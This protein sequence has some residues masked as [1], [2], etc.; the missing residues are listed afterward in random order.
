MPTPV[1]PDRDVVLRETRWVAVLIIPVLL[2]AF[3]I[4][5]FFPDSSGEHFAWPIKPRMSAMMLGATYFTGAIY[6]SVV[7]RSKAWHQVRLGLL[8]VVLFASILG[9][10][11]IMHWD[12]FS[13][14][15]PQFW[16]WV[17]L[18]W[19]LPFVLLW[20]WIR[21]E[22]R[23]RPLG[24]V[25]DEV[26]LNR[27]TR[28]LIGLIGAGLAVTSIA[29]FAIPAAVIALWPWKLSSLTARITS[30]ELGLFAFFMLEVALVGRWSEVRKLLFPQLVSPVI[31]VVSVL[32][33]WEN[34]DQSNPFT[35]GFVAFV[36]IVFLV[37][38]PAL[39]FPMESKRKRLARSSA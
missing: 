32:V 30:A 18:Y 39:Y 21:N 23:A 26:F 16:L 7:A 6:F 29:L 22:R 4:L 38:F 27:R 25:A 1:H 35:W 17:V 24:T 3:V 28:P 9:I 12:K 14:D 36:L 33:S 37:G 34:F 11:T 20:L 13:H 2:A 19:V 31:F 8:P 10:A 5:Y 15:K